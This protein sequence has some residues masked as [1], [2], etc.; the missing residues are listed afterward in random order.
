VIA[1]GPAATTEGRG[2]SRP[3]SSRPVEAAISSEFLTTTTADQNLP[4]GAPW[5]RSSSWGS[6]RILFR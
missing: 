2:G 4:S 1:A 3:W 6:G 5:G